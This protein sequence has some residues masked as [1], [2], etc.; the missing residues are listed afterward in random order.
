MIEKTAA[1]DD[2]LYGEANLEAWAGTMAGLLMPTEEGTG[3]SAE[4]DLEA[5]VSNDFVEAYNDFHKAAIA[6]QAAAFDI[7][8]PS[9]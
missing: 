8:L 9:S 7:A 2:A 4:V 3:L 6:E 5:L 1:E